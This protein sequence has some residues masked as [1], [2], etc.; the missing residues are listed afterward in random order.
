MSAATPF[1]QRCGYRD[2]WLVCI[3]SACHDGPHRV[4]FTRA[5][6]R[7]GPEERNAT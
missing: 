1:S 6:I 2:G 7:Y 4:R 5:V 3:L